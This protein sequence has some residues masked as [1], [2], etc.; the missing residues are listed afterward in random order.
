MESKCVWGISNSKKWKLKV[1]KQQICGE[2]PLSAKSSY[3][4]RKKDG[5]ILYDKTRNIINKFGD[6][7]LFNLKSHF[8]Y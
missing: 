3:F 7:N 4:N 8:G 5:H 2:S 1:I 6:L